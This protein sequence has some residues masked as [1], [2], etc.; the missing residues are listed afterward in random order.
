MKFCVL[1]VYAKIVE[2]SPQFRWCIKYIWTGLVLTWVGAMVV[3][4]FECRPFKRLV[5]S[6]QS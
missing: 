1:A 5:I 2:K 6:S 3:T 4:L